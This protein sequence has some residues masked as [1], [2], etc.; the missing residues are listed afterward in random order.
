VH[1]ALRRISKECYYEADDPCSNIISDLSFVVGPLR[2][3]F[4]DWQGDQTSLELYQQ[5]LG[6]RFRRRLRHAN[7]VDWKKPFSFETPVFDLVLGNEAWVIALILTNDDLQAFEES[8]IS[9]VITEDTDITELSRRWNTRCEA[10][11]ECAL[12]SAGLSDTLRDVAQGS[13][14]STSRLG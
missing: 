8:G 12:S 1:R 11:Y 14:T 7:M 2:E 5:M 4:S 6:V 10:F 9:N 13:R 3:V